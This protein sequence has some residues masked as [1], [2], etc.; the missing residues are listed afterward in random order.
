MIV[1]DL[2]G[3][4]VAVIPSETDPPLIVDSNTVLPCAI[5]AQLLEPVTWGQPQILEPQRG[6][7]VAELPE[8]HAPEVGWKASDGLAVPEPF[9]VT[10]SEAPNH[11]PIITLR[12]TMRK[13]TLGLV[14]LTFGFSCSRIK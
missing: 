10:I 11:M 6:V 7:H 14:K 4:G 9:G 3:V 13:R 1:D 12:V 2:N 5:S 8:H